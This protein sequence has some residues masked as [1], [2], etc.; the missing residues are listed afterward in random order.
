[1]FFDVHAT[2]IIL[3]SVCYY[4]KLCK[5]TMPY[6]GVQFFLMKIQRHLVCNGVIYE[7]PLQEIHLKANGCWLFKNW[8]LPNKF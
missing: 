8:H 4:S 3:I 2:L 6:L 5:A 1:M 7:V